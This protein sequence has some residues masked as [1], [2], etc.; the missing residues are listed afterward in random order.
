MRSFFRVDLP[1][2]KTKQLPRFLLLFLQGGGGVLRGISL[3]EK[4][5]RHFIEK[6]T[7]KKSEENGHP[8]NV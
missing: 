3:E 2:S 1:Q 7:W 8:G 6:Y 4:H 5:G